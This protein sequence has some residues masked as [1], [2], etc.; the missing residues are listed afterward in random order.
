MVSCIRGSEPEQ[1]PLWRLSSATPQDARAQQRTHNDTV[2]GR[3]RYHIHAISYVHRAAADTAAVARVGA[4]YSLFRDTGYHSKPPIIGRQTALLLVL[5]L[6]MILAQPCGGLIQQRVD[7]RQR[8]EEFYC[9]S[10]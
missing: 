5:V 6:V 1:E 8:S 3:H 7:Y 2:R 10:S 9:K 4:V